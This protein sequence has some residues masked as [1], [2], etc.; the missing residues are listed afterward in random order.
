MM[1]IMIQM[2]LLVSAILVIQKVLGDKL[3]AYVRYGLWLLVVVRLLLP[4]NLIDSSFSILRITEKAA[5]WYEQGAKDNVTISAREPASDIAQQERVQMQYPKEGLTLEDELWQVNGKSSSEYES[6]AMQTGKDVR[7]DNH[8]LSDETSEAGSGGLAGWVRSTTEKLSFRMI[9]CAVWLAGSLIVGGF[10]GVS[11]FCFRRGLSRMRTGYRGGY[12]GV[13]RGKHIP[14][15]LV[16]NLP[17]P[18]LVG[19]FRPAIYVGADI[20]TASDTFR[21]AVTHEEVHYLH[22]DYLWAFVRMALVT[23]YWFHPFVWIAAAASARDGE[24]ACDYGT[25]QRIG[26]KERF[27]YGEMLLKFSAVQQG[28]RVYSYGTMLRP[29]KSELKE[30]ILRLTK[31]K[32][33]RTWAAALAALFMVALAGCAFTGAEQDG[34]GE[35]TVFFT[36]NPDENTGDVSDEEERNQSKSRMP[37][38]EDVANDTDE[39]KDSEDVQSEVIDEPQQIEPISADIAGGTPFGADGPMLDFAG[40]LGAGQESVVIFHDYFGLIIYDLIN[41]KVVSS[42][43]LASIGCQMTQ[44]DDACEVAVSADGT[45]VWLHPRSKRY[46]YRYEIEKDLLYQEP[47]VKNFQI[48]LEGKELFDRYLVTEETAQRQTGWHSNY[49]YEEYQDEQG[50]HSTYIYLYIPDGEALELDSLQ[51]EWDDM[52]FELFWDNIDAEATDGQI[53]FDQADEFPYEYSGVVKQV[54]II[55]DK[56]CDYSYIPDVFGG[57]THPI[58]QEIIKHDGIDYVAE[59]GT[60]VVAAADGV[61][62]ATGFSAKYGNYVVLLHVNGEMTY[63]CQCQKVIVEKD[64]QVKRGEKIATV[65]STGQSTGSHLHFAL[66]SHGQFVNPEE[67]MRNVIPLDE[68][69]PE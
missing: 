1:G 30:R 4:I 21:Y 16:K 38:E 26:Q 35:S 10:L 54:R 24:I 17:S 55:Y 39:A 23:V 18:C 66:S 11:Q 36:D 61:V 64:A 65:G 51:C 34:E 58:T 62:Y 31:G 6:T 9:V 19:F 52:I 2:A 53:E 20:D 7:I 56:P 67:Y 27:A 49:L 63:Y 12:M 43:D 48:D 14:I 57:R 32:R 5:I 47:L 22:R 59:E 40:N 15:Y 29:G 37:G 33:S 45:T 28:K 46:M 41:Q 69:E 13:M 68:A 44:G 50:S 25:I 60:D 3:H 8:T 42:L